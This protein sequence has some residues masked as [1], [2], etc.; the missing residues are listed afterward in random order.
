ME[1]VM[2]SLPGVGVVSKE[3]V[4]GEVAHPGPAPTLTTCE[5]GERLVTTPAVVVTTHEMVRVSIWTGV[6]EMETSNVSPVDEMAVV[7][8]VGEAAKS[9]PRKAISSIDSGESSKKSPPFRR[10]RTKPHPEQHPSAP[11]SCRVWSPGPR[12]ADTVAS[13]DPPPC[14]ISVVMSCSTR[15]PSI[16]A[17]NPYPASIRKSNCQVSVSGSK[18]ST[19][20]VKM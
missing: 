2:V 9:A 18:K 12:V 11:M 6:D 1:H 15:L 4:T 17:A 20:S 10:A 7:M 19:V 13:R 16:Q 5:A 14:Q 3:K 8:A